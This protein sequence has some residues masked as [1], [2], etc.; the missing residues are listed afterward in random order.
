MEVNSEVLA[1]LLA[2]LGM[3]ARLDT[4]SII[5]LKLVYL[6]FTPG[7]VGTQ[8]YPKCLQHM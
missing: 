7:F 3:K 1:P 8:V 6:C 2:S 4:S 5:F